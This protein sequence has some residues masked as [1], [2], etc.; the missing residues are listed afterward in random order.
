MPSIISQIAEWGTTLPYWE[1]VALERIISGQNF[2]DDVYSNLLQLLLEDGGLSDTKTE[3]P[4]LRLGE[5]ASAERGKS[6]SKMILRKIA[7]LQNINALVSNQVLEFGDNITVIFGENGSGKSGYARVIASAAFTRGDNEILRNVK[8]PVDESDELS[9]DIYLEKSD[10]SIETI[11]HIIGRPCPEMASFYV[12]DSTSVHAHLTKS[13]PMSFSPANLDVLTRLA[14]VTDEV[15]KRLDQKIEKIRKPKITPFIFDGETEVSKEILKLSATSDNEK[16]YALGQ[17][18]EADA[19]TI[20]DLDR[21]IAELKVVDFDK[22]LKTVEQH[23]ADITNL[24]SALETLEKGLDESVR[25]ETFRMIDDWK[26]NNVVAT[27]FSRENFGAQGVT[28]VGTPEWNTFARAALELARRESRSRETYPPRNG[29]CLLCHQPLSD[30]AHHY[31]HG[32]WESLQTESHMAMAELNTTLDQRQAN[33]VRSNDLFFTPNTTAYRYLES[34]HSNEFNQVKQFVSACQNRRRKLLNSIRERQLTQIE[35]LP[36]SCTNALSKIIG[37]L[38]YQ[39]KQLKDRQSNAESEIIRLG[40]DLRL[41]QHR[42]T[43]SGILAEVLAFIETERWIQKASLA[44]VRGSTTPI[45]RKYN[46]LFSSLVTEK[47][48]ELFAATLVDMKC[49]L[50][51]EITYKAEKGK[52]LKQLGLKTNEKFPH[53]KAAPEKVLSEGEQRAVALADFFTELALDDQSSGFILDDPVTSLDFRWKETI[54]ENVVKQAEQKQVI[55]FTHDLHFLHC[56]KTKSDEHNVAIRGH[57]IQKRNEVPGY[58]FNDNSPMSEKDYKTPKLA[59]EF[60]SKAATDGVSAIEQQV[61]LD[62]GFS[63]LRTSYEAFIMFELFNGVVLRFEERISG[64]RLKKI[65]IDDSIRDDVAESIGRISRYIGAHLHSD[66][67]AAQK[68]TPQ[69]LIDEITHFEQLK[70]SHKKFKKDHGITD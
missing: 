29:I 22:Q 2:T 69:L 1:Q 15:R 51:V 13:N 67:H 59:K 35:E 55:I 30:S 7:N 36:P 43:L 40:N 54:A 38:E 70:N 24:I 14:E 41:L 60:A 39:K 53:D 17:F 42:K 62:A 48:V 16:I 3:R 45:T 27:S 18:T 63:A 6:T 50:D 66:V 20:S 32:L 31:L 52:T 8:K 23:I 49:P 10:S 4:P 57:W 46:G 64:D 25:M 65:Y 61:Y 12:F 19:K 37:A 47:Y 9:A 21:Q 28:A 56:L 68:P 58:V 11:H 33:L 26:A 44:K 34:N 5:Y